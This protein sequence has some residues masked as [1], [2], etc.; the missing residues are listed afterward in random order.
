MLANTVNI[1]NKRVAT[2]VEISARH[3]L[4]R[5][6]NLQ[7]WELGVVSSEGCREISLVKA[8]GPLLRVPNSQ[9]D[10]PDDILTKTKEEFALLGLTWGTATSSP[11]AIPSISIGY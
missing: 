9:R 1:V 7:E 8:A 4:W 5:K 3:Y 10:Q 11:G 6:I 2:E